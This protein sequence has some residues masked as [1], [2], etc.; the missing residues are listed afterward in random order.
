MSTVSITQTHTQRSRHTNSIA[1]LRLPPSAR[2]ASSP[3]SRRSDASTRKEGARAR[4]GENQPKD[5]PRVCFCNHGASDTNYCTVSPPPP[6][7]PPPPPP[8][9]A[10]R[11]GN[12]RCCVGRLSP[13]TDSPLQPIPPPLPPATQQDGRR[14]TELTSSGRV[15][16]SHRCFRRAGSGGVVALRGGCFVR[17]I[18]C[19]LRLLLPPLL[20]L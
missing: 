6:S 2:G 8:A 14:E 10:L 5:E 12:L 11:S 19:V 3:A 15:S 16:R 9:A 4:D 20:R 13:S 18:G 1:R 17:C 7:L